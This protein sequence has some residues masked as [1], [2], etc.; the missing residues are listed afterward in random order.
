MTT[1]SRPTVYAF[2][3]ESGDA[4][5]NI[6]RGA[7]PYFVVVFVETTEPEAVRTAKAEDGLQYADMV[8]G[9]LAERFERGKSM[10]DK[11]VNAKLVDL[12]LCPSE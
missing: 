12:W 7:S 1:K 5:G 11:E 4:G 2:M 9:V 6:H 10:Y 8:A 3:D